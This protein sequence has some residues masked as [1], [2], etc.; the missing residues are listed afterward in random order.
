MLGT[1]FD[2]LVQKDFFEVHCFE[3][4]VK[5]TASGMT[6]I[7]THG[8]SVRVFGQKVETWQD[9]SHA[10]P[11]W[12]AGETSFKNAPMQAVIFQFENQYHYQ[13]DFPKSIANARFTGS[14]TNDNWNVAL[15]SI[16]L[17]LKLKFDKTNPRTI[18][19]S[20]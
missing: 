10:K 4:K 2:V 3:G 15:Q 17:P 14:F 6:S 7:L 8:K 9:E 20:E 18:T 13:V 19:I 12:M 11:S 5:V 16:C 1:Q